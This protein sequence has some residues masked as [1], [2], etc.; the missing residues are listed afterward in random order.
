VKRIALIA[1]ALAFVGSAFGQARKPLLYVHDDVNE[2]NKP[3]IDAFKAAFDAEGIPYVEAAAP[4][5]PD[6]SGFDLIVVHGIVR[7][8]NME[9]PIRDWLKS[10]PP[11]AGKKA[12]I[13]ITANR[14][15]L[16]ALEKD[17]RKLLAKD[18]AEI[19]DAVSMATKGVEK[20]AK[21]A[22]VSDFVKRMR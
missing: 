3:Y 6:L 1:L 13:F 11:L 22:A 8:F 21:D 7:A 18:G 12:R 14:W 19:V 5:V 9:S 20:A 16:K 17:I 2:N 10:G 4:A 15:S